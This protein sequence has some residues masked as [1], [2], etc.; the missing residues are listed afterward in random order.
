MIWSLIKLEDER[1]ELIEVIG[2]LKAW[3]HSS[4]EDSQVI[5]LSLTAH[6]MRL[7]AL[8]EEILANR[9]KQHLEACAAGIKRSA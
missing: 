3:Q 5:A 4:I 7:S 8:E 1:Q 2:N 9:R 6:M